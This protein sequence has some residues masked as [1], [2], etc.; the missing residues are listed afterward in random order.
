M[1]R[2]RKRFGQNFLVD[3]VCIDELITVIAPKFDD[4]ILEIGPGLGALTVPLLEK[5]AHLEVIEIDRDLVAKLTAIKSNNK[6]TIYQCD[7][8][9]FDFSADKK[10]RR[11]IGNLPY[12]ISTPLIFHLLSHL[13]YIQDMHFMLQKEVV[14]RICAQSGDRNYGRLSVMVQAKCYPEKLFEI[15][16]QKFSPPPKVTSGFIRLSRLQQPIIPLTLE[17]AFASAVKLAF[18]QPRKTLANNLKH[19]MSSTE[20]EKLGIN[21]SLRPQQLTV[22]EYLAIA[23][24]M[25]QIN[26]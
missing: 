9:S 26:L 17:P 20:L 23:Q 15:E 18:S 10:V 11:I 12:N 25:R 4:A 8:L 2:P 14:D 21:P 24:T 5:V 19:Q 3:P 6:L 16:P 7:A 1:H 22:N 13:S